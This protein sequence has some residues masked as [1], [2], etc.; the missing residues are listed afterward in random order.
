LPYKNADSDTEIISE[1]FFNQQNNVV[2]IEALEELHQKVV[3]RGRGQTEIL[4]Y[5]GRT[6]QDIPA[7]GTKVDN[8]VL[9][10]AEHTINRTSI[11][12]DYTFDEFFAKL[13]KFTGVLEQYRQFSI[14]NESLV[15]RQFNTE[16]FGKFTKEPKNSLGYINL[17]DYIDDKRV[18]AI[19][20]DFGVGGGIGN[21]FRQTLPAVVSSFN[22]QIRVEVE[23]ETNVKTGDQSIPFI[24]D[25]DVDPDRRLNNPV[26]FTDENGFV[27]T[28]DI[29]LIEDYQVGETD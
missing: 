20:F 15:K 18:N 17:N 3:N 21:V 22:N 12:S 1:Q 4:T 16:I 5:L 7:L 27:E 6:F 29:R 19:Q 11:T 14:P 8:F 28:A 2:S 10:S 9:T 23:T 25:G 13:N 24:D 26:I